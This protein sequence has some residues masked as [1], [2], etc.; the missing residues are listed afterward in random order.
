MFE[1]DRAAARGEMA[2]RKL[3]VFKHANAL[4]NAPA[5]A[6]FDR[7]KVGRDIGGEFRDVKDSGINNYPPARQ[8]S[9]YIIE[10]NREG[11]PEGVEI[12]EPS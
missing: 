6:L 2:T 11:L 9:D 10:I 4:G 12:I 5:H 1:H 7:V 3:I 8:F